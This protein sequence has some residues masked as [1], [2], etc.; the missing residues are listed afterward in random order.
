MF[1]LCVVMCLIVLTYAGIP[2]KPM[3]AKPTKGIRVV[4][5]RFTDIPFT[6]EYKYDGERAQIHKLEDGRVMIYSRNLE[7]HTEVLAP[8]S[9]FFLCPRSLII[10]SPS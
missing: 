9:A 6:C 1:R 2:I 7:N 3:L 10:M 4:L 5:D 8:P